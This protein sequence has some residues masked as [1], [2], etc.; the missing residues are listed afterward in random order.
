M[1]FNTFERP[2][3]LCMYFQGDREPSGGLSNSTSECTSHGRQTNTS[4]GSATN[5]G[6]TT[7]QPQSGGQSQ[8]SG[9]NGG[10]GSK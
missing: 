7:Q 5:G 1:P 6:G 2:R 8:G 3:V 10:S 4:Q 9:G